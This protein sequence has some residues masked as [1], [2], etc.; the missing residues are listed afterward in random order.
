MKDDKTFEQVA[1]ELTMAW[2]EF[3]KALIEAFK[4]DKC[5]EWLVKKLGE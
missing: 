1:D 3:F 2:R 4:L 5:V